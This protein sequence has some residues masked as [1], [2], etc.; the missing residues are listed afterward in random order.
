[1]E[2]A[3]ESSATASP[4][5][6][7]AVVPA[8]APQAT[9]A[10]QTSP[11]I[12]IARGAMALLSAQPLTWATSLLSAALVPRF[13]GDQ[14]LGEYSLAMTIVGL[15]G[16]LVLL[17]MPTSLSRRVAANPERAAIDG[18]AAALL[19]VVVAVVSGG[20]LAVM[21]PLVG[22]AGVWVD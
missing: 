7:M 1:M 11:T 10:P 9:Q 22:F 16:L 20:L 6:V 12:V 15:L 19:L 8:V 3:G 21:V 18:P 13:L 2:C 17:G 14:V 5:L 4:S